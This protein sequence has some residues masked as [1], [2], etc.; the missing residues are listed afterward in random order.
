MFEK[1]KKSKLILNSL[2]VFLCL[3]L[4]S[5][6]GCG[7][8][9]GQQSASSILGSASPN[10]M[11][12][13]GGDLYLKYKD[14]FPENLMEM[15]VDDFKSMLVSYIV[16]NADGTEEVAY[17][18][19]SIVNDIVTQVE[20]DYPTMNEEVYA[21]Q[22][23]EDLIK[24]HPAFTNMIMNGADSPDTEKLDMTEEE[25]SQYILD[26]ITKKQDRQSAE[27]NYIIVS[28][29]AQPEIQAK[30][31]ASLTTQATS[32]VGLIL[33]IGGYF[34]YKEARAHLN[35]AEFDLL[36]KH[37][38]YWYSTYKAAY[39]AHSY[40]EQYFGNTHDNSKANAFQH[41]LLNAYLADFASKSWIHFLWQTKSKGLWWARAITN[42]HEVGDN[43]D[44]PSGQMDLHNN[45]I[46]RNV[47]DQHSTEYGRYATVRLGRWTVVKIRIGTYVSSSR[48]RMRMQLNDMAK[49]A[50]FINVAEKDGNDQLINW[51][52][53]SHRF[54]SHAKSQASGKLL[55]IGVGSNHSDVP[56][57]ESWY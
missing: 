14:K 35:D 33:G 23:A 30:I 53:S 16:Q 55:Y 22:I 36:A 5:M 38:W 34:A 57:Y 42:A 27:I 18:P 43:W 13:E 7:K 1:L 41:S 48:Y 6:Y 15:T 45:E 28:E 24:N 50:V 29:L 9:T 25:F 37:P 56:G 10:E 44:S 47:Y 40:T 52:R 2:G 49:S 26:E 21:N 4:V 8:L 39:Y 19:H 32:Q 51:D 3:A 46:G 11:S 12:Q 31:K 20:E 17:A 54:S